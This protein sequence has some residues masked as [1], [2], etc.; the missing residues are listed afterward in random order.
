MF[1][2]WSLVG[3]LIP[4]S[5]LGFM[6]LVVG[7]GFGFNLWRADRPFAIMLWFAT[8]L[9]PALIVVTLKST[10]RPRVFYSLSGV[11]FM[12]AAFWL[13]HD[14]IWMPWTVGGPWGW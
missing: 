10:A 4:A 7:I 9:F 8:V 12:F 14:L 2:K 1:V 11:A 6:H 3:L 13:F 5:L